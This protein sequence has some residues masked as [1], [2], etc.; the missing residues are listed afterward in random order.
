M[1]AHDRDG[2]GLRIKIWKRNEVREKERM[3]EEPR[4]MLAVQRIY[5]QSLRV[6]VCLEINL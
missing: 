3:Q 5:T 2:Q 4:E 6:H 1:C